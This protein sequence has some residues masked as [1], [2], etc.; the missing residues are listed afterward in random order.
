M[1][2]LIGVF[3]SVTMGTATQWH[4]LSRAGDAP[5]KE[6]QFA[7][8]LQGWTI[9]PKNLFHT[10]DRGRTWRVERSFTDTS[11]G[12]LA[13]IDSGHVLVSYGRI[14]YPR[15]L[16]WSVR[17]DESV[18]GSWVHR[19]YAHAEDAP[20]ALQ[21][22]RLT[23]LDS[24]HVWHLG[25]Q[26]TP[27]QKDVAVRTTDGGSTWR[28]VNEFV[29][30]QYYDA[31]FTDTV[32]GWAAWDVIG[33]TTNAG[34]SWQVLTSNFGARRIQMFD[35]LSGW[36]LST[37]GLMHTTDG[38]ASWDTAVA[39]SGL[40]A[41][42][43]CNP[44]H[45]VAV[46]TGG[47]ILHTTEAGVTWLQDTSESFLDLYAVWMVD[48]AHAWASG[49]SGVVLGMGDWAL[50]G[51]E[52]Q[53]KRWP[54]RL[55]LTSVRPNPCRGTLWIALHGGS[56]TVVVYDGCGRPVASVRC[57]PAREEKLDLR[58]LPVGVYFVR[59]PSSPQA[60]VRFVLLR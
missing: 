19:F 32:T 17:I 54:A 30:F 60:G 16:Y 40:Q 27:I 33:K 45:G 4:V 11:F 43:F 58:G 35:S 26:Y 39:E 5:L 49:D 13:V 8:S 7:D 48:S 24:M 51:V 34:D 57:T 38:W 25:W 55:E 50:P 41:M 59:V 14:Y 15:Y 3:L 42:R 12:G 56:G 23:V 28:Q 22:C 2:T 18:H 44:R 47:V 6:V 29:G 10:T 52:E 46:G 36:V 53:V 9:A 31:S 1:K 37:S 20:L 21:A